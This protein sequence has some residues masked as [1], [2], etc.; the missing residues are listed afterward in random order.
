MLLT[1]NLILAERSLART[2][3]LL[4]QQCVDLESQQEFGIGVIQSGQLMR[5]QHWNC[6]LIR[7]GVT[8]TNHLT[9]PIPL[10]ALFLSP[11]LSG[12]SLNMDHAYDE[13]RFIINLENPWQGIDR[14]QLSG[15]ACVLLVTAPRLMDALSRDNSGCPY[16][17]VL[18]IAR[19]KLD[20]GERT[21]I[22]TC[23]DINMNIAH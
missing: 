23:S 15:P 22:S 13:G 6:L 16:H 7:I 18:L 8:V 20:E 12:L 17:P 3:W 2:R 11:A 19:G 9:L 4:T 1:S 5:E 10:S 21:V 14:T